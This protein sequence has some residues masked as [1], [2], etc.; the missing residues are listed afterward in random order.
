MNRLTTVVRE[1]TYDGLT[2]EVHLYAD[3][4]IELYMNGVCFKSYYHGPT[5][6]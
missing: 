3:A 4:W 1:V 5:T 6:A 2:F